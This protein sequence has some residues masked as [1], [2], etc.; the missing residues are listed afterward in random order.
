M[1]NQGSEAAIKAYKSFEQTF[2]KVKIK[3]I[4]VQHKK[5]TKNVKI[6][7]KSSKV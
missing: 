4:G 1:E 3:I 7:I 6:R 2:L 5:M